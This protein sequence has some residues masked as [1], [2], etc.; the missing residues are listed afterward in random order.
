MR[1][2]IIPQGIRR[3]LPAL[4]NQFIALIKD[5]SPRL[6][7]RPARQP[8]RAVPH[9]AGRRGNTGNQS[10]AAA[11]GPL[12]P[13][14]HRPAD[15]PR[16][17]DRPAAARRPP[18]RGARPT[19]DEHRRRPRMPPM[20]RDGVDRDA[21]PAMS[22]EPTAAPPHGHGARGVDV[23]RGRP[24][25]LR[26]QPGAA[27][28]RPRACPPATTACVIGPSGSGKSTAAARAS[29]GLPNPPPATCCSTA[30]R[31]WPTTPTGCGSG[32]AWC[33]STSTCSRTRPCAK[34]HARAPQAQGLSKDEARERAIVDSSTG[35]VWP[36]KADVAARAAFRRPAA[37]RRDR[38][39]A[40]DGSRGD[41][42]RRGHLGARPRAGQGRARDHVRAR[43]RGHDDARRH[44][45][46][47]LRQ[48]GP[49]QVLF[50]DQG[51][52]LESGPPDKVFDAPEQTACS[53]SSP[54]C[55]EGLESEFSRLSGPT[56][57]AARRAV[58]RRKIAVGR[59]A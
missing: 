44:P 52:V 26:Q 51:R 12:L 43:R 56:W 32:S 57:P 36:H 17:R 55:S 25:R 29:T 28:H 45:R 58:M 22:L 59:S 19:N 23:A 50:M 40:G 4:V 13:G 37:A 11:R 7:P 6:L 10:R 18:R 9:R 54:R 35:W 14:D 16:Q 38:P 42:L 33:S 21:G 30:A 24:P 48:V 31:C 41:A 39:G 53:A 46:D 5:S 47:G 15:A 2:V 49:Q 34:H 27:R 3:V 8:A 20:T 1:L